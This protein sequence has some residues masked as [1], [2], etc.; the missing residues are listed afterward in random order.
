MVTKQEIGIS[1]YLMSM[2]DSMGIA[3][4]RRGPEKST[5]LSGVVPSK[6]VVEEKSS[7]KRE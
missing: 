7:R 3:G 1:L 5:T 4:A 6:F 2:L